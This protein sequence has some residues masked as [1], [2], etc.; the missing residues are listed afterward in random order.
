MEVVLTVLLAAHLLAVNLGSAGPLLCIWL[1]GRAFRHG[2]PVADAVGRDLARYALAAT[3]VGLLLGGA[4][5]AWMF[6]QGDSP[7][8]RAAGQFPPSRWWFATGEIAFYYVCMFAYLALWTRWSQRPFWHGL[9]AVS[10]ATNMLYHFPPLW[11]MV[12]T[13]AQHPQMA[14]LHID[15]AQYRRLLVDPEI[16]SRVVHSWLAAVAVAGT[17]LVWLAAGRG[18]VSGGEDPQ[19]RIA[20]GGAWIALIPTGIQFLVG[21]WVLVELPAEARDAVIGGDLPSTALLLTSLTFTLVLLHILVGVA[22]G[23]VDRRSAR[24]AVIVLAL[25]VLLMSGTLRRIRHLS[26]TA[27]SRLPAGPVV[28]E[29]KSAMATGTQ[30]GMGLEATEL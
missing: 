5:L 3:T 14:E 28:A 19:R 13:L 23:G 27:Q 12:T 6:Y 17:A 9:L 25:V 16:A 1:H 4:I 30:G 15:P 11:T 21:M 26:E 7:F 18:T 20:V 24:R 8:L 29:A 2:D 10:A 22:G